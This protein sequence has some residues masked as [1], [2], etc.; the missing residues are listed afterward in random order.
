[1]KSAN[2]LN[3]PL[4]PQPDILPLCLLSMSAAAA[5]AHSFIVLLFRLH[6]KSIRTNGRL[7]NVNVS[8]PSSP[9]SPPAVNQ[10]H[11]VMWPIGGGASG[12]KRAA[13]REPGPETSP[14]PGPRP[15]P[16]EDTRPADSR[17]FVFLFHT[18]SVHVSC[19]RFIFHVLLLFLKFRQVCSAFVVLPSLLLW[20]WFFAVRVFPLS[21]TETRTRARTRTWTWSCVTT[22]CCKELAV[23]DSCHRWGGHNQS[24][25]SISTEERS[26]MFTVNVWNVKD[27]QRHWLNIFRF[28]EVNQ[29]S[30]H[31]LKTH[32]GG[33][34]IEPWGTPPQTELRIIWTIQTRQ[35]L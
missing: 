35:D 4:I 23:P 6:S 27:L 17:N 7:F 9:R 24:E 12:F 10:T 22:G 20:H 26:S 25:C 5:A 29:S 14:E 19:L 16:A 32:S 33:P 8:V 15:G 1:M 18:W 2:P 34:R 21:S 11:S 28:K 30:S 31:T 13:L 3:A